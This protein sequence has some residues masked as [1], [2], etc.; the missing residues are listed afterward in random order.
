MDGYLLIAVILMET[1]TVPWG[2]PKTFMVEGV[3]I[4]SV[5]NVINN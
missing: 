2:F 3:A 5:D 4:V 1:L